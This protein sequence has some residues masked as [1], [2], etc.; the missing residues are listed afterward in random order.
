MDAADVDGENT[1]DEH[2]Y[3]VVAKE[4]EGD[5]VP[6]PG[7]PEAQ[8]AREVEVLGRAPAV[9]AGL[10]EASTDEAPLVEWEERGVLEDVGAIGLPREGE[11]VADREVGVG[12]VS[13]PLAEER[14]NR[15][16]GAAI[17]VAG[18]DGLLRHGI[19]GRAHDADI[20]PLIR[21]RRCTG[22][23]APRSVESRND[24][25]RGRDRESPGK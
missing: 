16:R 18:I 6:R 22:P 8:L 14:G 3:V 1:V 7:E 21:W 11:R 5:G 13:V 12:D 19:P 23:A 25:H 20:V 15:R 9:V 2:K 24:H 17:D 10:L 4:R